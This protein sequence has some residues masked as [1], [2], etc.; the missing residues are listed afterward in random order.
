MEQGHISLDYHP[1]DLQQCVDD[2]VEIFRHQAKKEEK[3]LSLACDLHHRMVLGDASRI[4]QILNNCC[5]TPLN[6]ASPGH[7]LPSG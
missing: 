6:T 3:N 7:L 4:S 1:I 5:P 2:C